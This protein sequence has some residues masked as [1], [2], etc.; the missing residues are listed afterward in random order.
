V[1][2]DAVKGTDAAEITASLKGEGD[3]VSCLR[4]S[5][6]QNP[7]FLHLPKVSEEKHDR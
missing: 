4:V 1:V 3:R 7:R 6:S 5:S 2:D